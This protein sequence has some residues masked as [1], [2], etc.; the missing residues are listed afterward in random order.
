MDETVK[1][2]LSNVLCRKRDVEA[3]I[4]KAIEVYVTQQGRTINDLMK[5][6]HDELEKVPLFTPYADAESID[7]LREKILAHEF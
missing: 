6:L 1:P 2:E 5:C 4:F 3:A 7:E